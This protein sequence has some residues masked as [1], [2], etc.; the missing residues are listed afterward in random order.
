MANLH[1]CMQH[2]PQDSLDPVVL[3]WGQLSL[4]WS[5]GLSVSTLLLC[6]LALIPYQQPYHNSQVQI[7]IPALPELKIQLKKVH[8]TYTQGKKVWGGSRKLS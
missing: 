3:G 4:L 5:P 6:L 7:T 2:S 8:L 1:F